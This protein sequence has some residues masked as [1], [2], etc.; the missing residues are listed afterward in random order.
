MN[1]NPAGLTQISGRRLDL[2]PMTAFALDVGHADGFGNDVTVA[3]DKIFGA[4]LGYAQRLDVRSIWWGT[5]LFLQGASGVKYP[6]VA[7]AFGTTDDLTSLFTVLRLDFSAAA[8]LTSA[9]SVGATLGITRATLEQRVFPATSVTG[10]PAFFGYRLDDLA[11]YSFGPK[12]GLL[13]RLNE[14]ARLGVA[15]T[16]PVTLDLKHGHLVS[17]Q[18]SIGLG[19]VT[20][21]QVKATGLDLPTEVGLGYAQ[22]VTPRLLLSLEADWIDWSNAVD[23]ATLTASDPDNPSAAPAI[24]VTADHKWRDQYVLAAGIAYTPIAAWTVYAGYSRARS[25]IRP[26][27]LTPILAAIAEQHATAG[28]SHR[29]G[30]QWRLFAAVEYVLRNQVTYTNP[31]LPFGPDARETLNFLVVHATL[32]RE[33]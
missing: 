22:D 3:N 12:V 31:T 29:L 23:T 15:Y 10:P 19:S 27:H 30:A 5:G 17:D 24:T 6:Q 20:Y 1:A 33:W 9:V 26:E 4:T 14:R 13:V 2:N 32:S 11:G 7:T 28:L 21:H 25:P 18:S 8:R 16:A